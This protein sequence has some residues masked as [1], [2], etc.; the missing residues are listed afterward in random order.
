[1]N[2]ALEVQGKEIG[3]DTYGR[4][5]YVAARVHQDYL[6]MYGKRREHPDDHNKLWSFD[7][8]MIYVFQYTH[9]LNR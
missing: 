3:H 7:L 1:M 4:L 9:C 6:Y 8:S 5:H 2:K